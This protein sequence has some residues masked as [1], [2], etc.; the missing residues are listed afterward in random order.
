MEFLTRSIEEHSLIWVVISAGFGGI[1]GAL[2]KFIFE[3]VIA[4]RYEQSI[5]AGKMLSRYRYP[6]LRTADSLDRRIENMI[7]FVD[8]QWYDDKK[9]DYYRLSTLYL[10]GSYLGWS[11]IIEDAAF[12]EYVLSDR[13]A[14]QFS[15][16]F[17]RVFKA[18]TNFGYFAHIGKNE[19]TE[20]EEASVPRFALTAIG[21]MMIRKTP[22]DGD[23]LP[24]LLGFVEFTKKLNE[25]PDFQKW[26]HY[27]EAA[28][29]TDQKQ[30]L[31]SARWHRLLIVAS[32]MRAFVSYL[33]PKKRQ[34]APRQ[35]AYLDQ[36]NP[37]VAEE[38]VKELKEMKMESL[39]VL[40]DQQK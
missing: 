29:L 28:I 2:I 19:F 36:M 11:K 21:E 16:C 14:R 3:T 4:L 27:L 35:I 25:S 5:S 22:E 34:T 9:D 33:D 23:R 24:E 6:L 17:N 30:S 12:I 37:K 13:K 1:I 38:V 18:L 8:R 15:K 20:L 32:I 40:P 39:I 31:T 26:F 10:F 7:R